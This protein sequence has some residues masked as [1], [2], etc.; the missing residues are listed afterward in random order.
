MNPTDA[1][2]R[3]DRIVSKLITGLTA[4]HRE[5]ATPCDEWTVHDLIAHMCGGAHMVAGTMLDEAPPAEA[6]DVL[7]DGPAAGWSEAVA[8]LRRA[9]SPDVLAGTYR[10]PFGEMPGET[11]LSV[12]VADLV[13]H[14]WDL[15]TATGQVAGIDDDL[16]SWA[17]STWR[18]IVPPEGRTGPGFK[19]AVTVDGD[20]SPVDQLVAY[21]GRRP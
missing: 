7:A 8:H 4:D 14:A 11:A 19:D 9:T 5:S 21:T 18:P 1:L 13:T 17:L 10:F 15:A 20:A 2:D 6:P 12:I 3:T 16:A